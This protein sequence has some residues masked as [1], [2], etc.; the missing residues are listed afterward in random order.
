MTEL[1]TSAAKFYTSTPAERRFKRWLNF[2]I[3]I[4]VLVLVGLTATPILNLKTTTYLG[5]P[6]FFAVTVGGLCGLLYVVQA[7]RDG[8]RDHAYFADIL[9]G[10]CLIVGIAMTGFYLGSGSSDSD[11]NTF[12]LLAA[13]VSYGG[14]IITLILTLFTY[15]YHPATGFAAS[16]AILEY[17]RPGLHAAEKRLNQWTLI[18]GAVTVLGI[19][20]T[21][22]LQMTTPETWNRIGNPIFVAGSLATLVGLVL[23]A[24]LGM[25]RPKW[26][27]MLGDMLIAVQVAASAVLVIAAILDWTGSYS[28]T[29]MW[30][31]LLLTAVTVM[32]RL[33]AERSRYSG[34]YIP[35]WL[36]RELEAFADVIIEAP[37]LADP[38]TDEMGA[39]SEIV[40]P[41]AVAM[42]IDHYLASVQSPRKLS[43]LVSLFFVTVLRPW[44]GLHLSMSRM[45]YL[46][47]RKFVY[48]IFVRGSGIYR[49]MI[50][51]KQL[52][53]LG[54][55]SDPRTYK[56]IGFEPFWERK[57]YKDHLANQIS[58]AAAPTREQVLGVIREREHRCK[59]CVVGS[60]AGGAV[61]AARLA[62]AFPGE[63]I[64]LEAGPY[65][66]SAEFTHAEPDMIA[67]IYK[68]GGMQLSMDFNM[69]VLQGECVGGSTVHNNGICFDPPDKVINDWRAMGAN[70]DNQKLSE[71]IQRIRKRLN[72]STIS[73]SMIGPGSLKFA[74][75]AKQLQQQNL[76]GGRILDGPHWFDLNLDRCL[77]CGY[78]N[79]G[80]RYGKKLSMLDTFI[81][82]AE[83]N[84]AQVIANC[85]AIRFDI[86]GEKVV[87][88]RCILDDRHDFYIH[89]DYFI[90]ACGAIASS[91]LLQNSGVGGPVGKHLSFNIG[92]SVSAE[93]PELVRGYD[94]VQMCGYLHADGYLLETLFNP[95]A[96]FALTMPGWFDD[97]FSN[98][99]RYAYFANGGVMV[100]SAAIG[101]IRKPWYDALGGFVGR[102]SRSVDYQLEDDPASFKALKDGIKLLSEIYLAA[103]ATRVVPSTY[104][105]LEFHK[106]DDAAKIGRAVE[107]SIK[108]PDDLYYASAHPQGGNAINQHKA[109]GV[110]D[111]T[112]KV[113][114]LNNLFVC[115]ASVFPT[116]IRVNPQ[117]SIMAI[118][119]YAADMMLPQ[120]RN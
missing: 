51:I 91:E 57:R 35:Y 114:D 97:H 77:G 45:G 102:L 86:D 25:W 32:A 78:C 49:R 52:A 119:D 118:A 104:T 94:G 50:Q 100:P 9:I 87:G 92:T 27:L 36:F 38:P 74:E 85:K 56:Q 90:V 6:I 30:I 110:I 109:K 15:H 73:E 11:T 95:P 75:G 117:L 4:L 103:G 61:A 1:T 72:V 7:V 31:M 16:A 5:N 62:E 65:I 55:Y 47:R 59:V 58:T 112:F 83:R 89:A 70:L 116:G 24:V 79:I 66:R 96:L 76:D 111:E 39:L 18:M 14:A 81:P 43:A 41:G 22:W 63:V 120:M 101:E 107:D 10:I 60:G 28:F 64:I 54:Y 99:Q 82:D 44:L 106:G 8:V 40:S 37:R 84:G 68:D 19:I 93:F 29:V 33:A 26:G 115:D 53:V 69:A 23:S 12:L 3:A 108:K 2:W 98:M 17:D 21:L 113:H 13:L 88:L 105:E 71:S 34:L 20:L 67:A 42:N 80:C 46:E 48:D